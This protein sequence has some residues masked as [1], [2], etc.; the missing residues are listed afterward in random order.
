MA[1]AQTG[2]EA[3]TRD[4]VLSGTGALNAS[5]SGTVELEMTGTI[6]MA[7]DGDVLI[8]DHAGDARVSIVAAGEDSEGFHDRTGDP[9][10]QLDDF[11][12]LIRVRGRS[13]VEVEGFSAFR[14][15]GSG[16][17]HLAGE[18]VWKTRNN[19][20]FWSDHGDTLSLE[21]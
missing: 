5:G 7:A 15:R 9:T 18:G 3:R 4:T 10:Y 11:Q 2:P 20:G 16:H 6:R 13:F 21:D 14:A 1:F 19:S 17:T 8:L 12:G